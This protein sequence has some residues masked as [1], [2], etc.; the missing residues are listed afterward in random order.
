M[1]PEAKI[2]DGKKSLPVMISELMEL[3]N[4]S[5]SI[6]SDGRIY[7]VKKINTKSIATEIPE[8]ERLPVVGD[9]E[10]LL[11]LLMDRG[12]LYDNSEKWS[13][14]EYDLEMYPIAPFGMTAPA[15]EAPAE[16]MG[17]GSAPPADMRTANSDAAKAV[18]GDESHSQTNEQVEGVNEGDIVKTDGQY[19]YAMLQNS[20]TL[21]IIKA[22]GA[23][24]E[25]VS[26]ITIM[27]MW[28]VEF[29]LIGNDR[30]AIVG[31][32]Y[33]PI[34]A[35]PYEDGNRPAVPDAKVM[36]ADYGWYSNDFT[37]LLVYDISKREDPKELR[38]VSMDGWNVST[39]VIGDIVYLVTN[40][41][42][43][44]VPYNQADSPAIMPYCRDTTEG[45]D[46]KPIG[47][48]RV[49]YVPDSTDTS[50]L[51][52]G[53]INAYDDAEFKPEAYL[54]AGSNLYMS[55]NAMYITKY[56]WEQ[57][58]RETD[59]N[60]DTEPWESYFSMEKTDILRFAIN[61][62]DVIYTGMGTVG[63]SPINQ[64]SMDEYKGYFRIAT[65]DW[66]SGTY[67]TV[68]KTSSMQMVG[69]T[70]PLA[71]GE[72]MQSMRFMGDM[73]YVVTFQN[74]DPLFTIDLADPSSPKVLG[75]LKIPGFSQYLHPVGNGLM[76]GI[77]RDTQ[78]TYTR[79]AYG[80][81]TVIGF[82]DAGMKASLFDVSNPVNPKEINMLRL[83]EGSTEVSYNPRALM[84]DSARGLYGLIAEKWDDRGNWSGDVLLLSVE[85]GQLSIAATLKT[86]RNV[87]GSRLCFIRNTL[88][89]VYDMGVDAYD[90]NNYTKLGG[91]TF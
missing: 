91:I 18:S 66:E 58:A 6:K 68:L 41:S 53:A 78:E 86:G 36:P 84:C 47:L 27:D 8:G 23:E 29:Y 40:K 43:M 60:G 64:Y 34:D 33:V 48:D 24:L 11:K 17:M 49:Y 81:E 4:P 10:M 69:R 52:I 80:V 55:Q 61:G 25:V 50:Y 30:L 54:G 76:L 26:T 16:S 28:G 87:Y 77:G 3:F 35:M 88:Y 65:T 51:L 1:E 70:E 22:E 85:D 15:P 79:D 38:R 67:V 9:K 39:R 20:N 74:M 37:V 31:S 44:S 89:I 63:G 71:P 82:Q 42:I 2:S 62:T 83:G 56:R 32:E 45:E 13:S 14:R 72:R 75:E 73:G 46:Y 57:I 90:Y 7:P 21:R 5:D 59:A 12:V 19:I